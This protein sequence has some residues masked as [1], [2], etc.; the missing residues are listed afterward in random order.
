MTVIIAKGMTQRAWL[1]RERRS[2]HCG[3]NA[4]QHLKGLVKPR[5]ARIDRIVALNNVKASAARLMAVLDGRA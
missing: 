1:A 3:I 4:R 5:G 2:D